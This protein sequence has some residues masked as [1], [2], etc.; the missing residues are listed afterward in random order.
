MQYS[1]VCV[2]V[3]STEYCFV[4][5]EIKGIYWILSS[6]CGRGVYWVLFCLHG[7]RF[8]WTLW[9]ERGFN[10]RILSA[11]LLCRLHTIVRD[12]WT[13][14]EVVLQ[15]DSTN[16][17][18]R[19]PFF[20]S[21]VTFFEFRKDKCWLPSCL[22]HTPLPSALPFLS[23][24]TYTLMAINCTSSL[25]SWLCWAA[26]QAAVLP[27]LSI[28]MVSNKSQPRKSWLY[29]DGPGMAAAKYSSQFS[30][31][32]LGVDTNPAESARH[33]GG[34]GL[35]FLSKSV[36]QTQQIPVA[37]HNR[38]QNLH[39][40]SYDCAKSSACGL[41]ASR[42]DYWNQLYGVAPNRLQQVQDTLDLA[43]IDTRPN[44]FSH[45]PP[46]IPSLHWTRVKF[47]IICNV[48]LLT[49]KHFREDGH[50]IS[51]ICQWWPHLVTPFHQTKAHYWWFLGGR[52]FMGHQQYRQLLCSHSLE[53]PQH[54][55]WHSWFYLPFGSSFTPFHGLT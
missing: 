23:H 16:Q 36:S 24:I 4:C 7:R 19:H 12:L 52:L 34:G 54:A 3:G 2:E 26:T 45:A 15:K 33:L 50:H 40:S 35:F 22:H 8:Y 14:T 48:R 39:H 47:H 29:F 42:L 20:Q 27:G 37:H 28:G 53:Q 43:C 51:K 6:L 41:V 10:E 5:V 9:V 17:F 46:L 1:L 31:T 25:I 55:T 32:Q 38:I 44:A 18:G 30:I 49:W 11:L 21:R 13:G